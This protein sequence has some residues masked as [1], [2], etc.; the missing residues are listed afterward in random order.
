MSSPAPARAAR[1]HHRRGPSEA[2]TASEGGEFAALG[3][4]PELCRVL[5]GQS[6]HTPF[7]IQVAS[8]PDSLAGRDVL[9]RGRTGSGKTVAFAVPVV[10]RLAG[11]RSQPG[12]PRAVILLP[13]RELATQ[14]AETVGPLAQAM[15]LKV[16]TIF[17]GVTQNP[18][19]AALRRGVD[20]VV[21]CPG[22]LDDLVG[23]GHC[24][25][26]AV[27]VT[28]LDEADHM[29]DLGFLPVVQKL[30]DKTPNG[31]QRLLFSATLDR[32]V[33]GIVRRYLSD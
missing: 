4:P 32:G 12:R 17:G 9:G 26:D 25:L 8:L 7:P 3:V 14:V 27:E 29:A 31:G 30:L 22:R 18:Q 33:D 20:V 6:I 28:V 11:R 23:Q 19:V 16:A 1:P 13:T 2:S 21:A 24:R 10:T 15:G 5:A